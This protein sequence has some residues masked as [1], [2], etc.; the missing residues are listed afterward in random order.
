MIATIKPS[1]YG[2]SSLHGVF[3]ARHWGNSTMSCSAC[4]TADA[5]LGDGHPCPGAAQAAPVGFGAPMAAPMA[6]PRPPLS[7]SWQNT[8]WL[9]I[10]LSALYLV[11]CVVRLVF[12]FHE[13]SRIESI[14]N[15]PGPDSVA[16]LNSLQSTDSLLNN[17]T[18][19]G[20]VAYLVGYL[21]YFAAVRKAVRAAG[22]NS[23]LLVKHWTYYAWRGAILV[24]LLASFFNAGSNSTDGSSDDAAQLI[25]QFKHIA[26]TTELYLAARIV[27]IGVLIVAV[28]VTRNR[29]RAAIQQVRPTAPF[30]AGYQPQGMAP[31]PY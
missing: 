28:V 14:L 9:S 15:A 17:L 11:V 4:N 12:T 1:P 7:N 16:Q 2:F 20:F 3:R 10:G 21:V 8:A 31:Q 6:A 5:V 24:S 13:T 29:V 18:L 25:D 27:T 22:L 23:A 30:G 26:M 19:V